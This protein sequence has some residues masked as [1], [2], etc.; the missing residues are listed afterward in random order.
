MFAAQQEKAPRCAKD[1]ACGGS[2]CWRRRRFCCAKHVQLLGDSCSLEKLDFQRRALVNNYIVQL[3]PAC[4]ETLHRR[5]RA[6]RLDA[7]VCFLQAARPRSRR[8]GVVV[9]ARAREALWIL[10]NVPAAL[11][12]R[13]L[14]YLPFPTAYV[15]CESGDGTGGGFHYLPS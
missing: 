15:Q 12:A 11:L 14:L 8:F 6:F 3:C 4:W 5:R 13:C 1:C 2:C 10:H 9:D 7:F